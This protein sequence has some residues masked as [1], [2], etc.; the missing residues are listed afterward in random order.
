VAQRSVVQYRRP[1]SSSARFRSLR[2]GATGRRAS[3]P[4]A[5]WCRITTGGTG[6]GMEYSHCLAPAAES[7]ASLSTTRRSTVF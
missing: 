6:Q 4:R 7:A 5:P 2:P 1:H 3:R